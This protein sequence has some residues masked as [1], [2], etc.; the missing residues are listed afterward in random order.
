M[1]TQKILVIFITSLIFLSVAKGDE[2]CRIIYTPY[3]PPKFDENRR[4]IPDVYPIVKLVQGTTL[5]HQ[6][7]VVGVGGIRVVPAFSIIVT[8][9]EELAKTGVCPNRP[10]PEICKLVA[11]GNSGF[12]FTYD[13][14]PN[15]LY[16]EL[17][18]VLETLK[19]LTSRGI[20][21]KEAME[22]PK[23]A[24][25]PEIDSPPLDQEKKSR[26]DID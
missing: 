24:D 13:R 25:S 9:W 3:G 17:D 8:K 14:G 22:S 19:E 1:L 7:D 18:F 21:T 16:H 11:L 2:D 23:L 12:G 6:E 26:R 5:F 10:S 20:C 4:R 15:L